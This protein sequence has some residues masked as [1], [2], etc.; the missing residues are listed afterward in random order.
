MESLIV[1]IAAAVAMWFAVNRGRRMKA[2][3]AARAAE[4]AGTM[5]RIGAP[6][7][8]T[9]KQ[10]EALKANNFEPAADWS[11]EEAALMLDGL[12]Y[13]RAV[14]AATTG[15]H[16]HA[17]EVQNQVFAFVMRDESIREYVRTSRPAEPLPRDTTFEQVAAFVRRTVR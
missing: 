7:T 9:R 15:R 16:D 11:R 12:G 4:T 8:M 10:M 14:L 17:V 3:R 1:A 5:P 2:R 6:G 13:A